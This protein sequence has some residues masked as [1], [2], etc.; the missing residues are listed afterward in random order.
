MPKNATVEHPTI[1]VVDP[2]TK[3]REYHKGMTVFKFRGRKWHFSAP[4]PAGGKFTLTTALRGGVEVAE[5][6]AP[7]FER[8]VTKYGSVGSQRANINRL[9][10]AAA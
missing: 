7:L 2:K 5:R 9:I 8:D 3:A 4:T 1:E 10:E 6:I